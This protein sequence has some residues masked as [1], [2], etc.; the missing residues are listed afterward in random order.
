M[1]FSFD[2]EVGRKEEREGGREESVKERIKEPR[3]L[4]CSTNARDN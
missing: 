2:T 4:V 1:S 3:L